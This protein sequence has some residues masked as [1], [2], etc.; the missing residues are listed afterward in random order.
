MNRRKKKLF[1]VSF[2]AAAAVATLAVAVWLYCGSSAVE[3]REI[4]V[5]L[6]YFDAADDGFSIAIL[7]DTHFG[8][9]DAPLA[10]KFVQLTSG[11]RPDMILL[12]GDFINGSPDPR[13]SMSME[14][15]ALFASSLHAK[16]GVFAVTGNH[17]LWYGR[18]KVMLA[19]RSAGV[20]VLS[21]KTQLIALPSGQKLQLAGFPDSTT[22]FTLPPP[23]IAP[24]LP[25]VALM[26]DAR[27]AALMP[28]FAFGVAGHTHGGQFRLCP[29]GGDRTSL[30]LLVQR[31]KDKLG[32]ISPAKRP[33]VLFDRWFTSYRGRKLFISAGLN[34]ERIRMRVFCPPEIVVMR[35][36][37]A[38]PQAAQNTYTVPEEL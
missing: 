29:D 38:D 35:L 11:L 10:E 19:L 16:Y 20:K 23:E 15:L 30:R 21:G 37:A 25:T 17:E 24:G 13:A 5:N 28:E 26:H 22:E 34:G 33:V 6:P 12:L 27:A 7:S 8:P 4:R 32:M 9:D 2:I 36:Y 1:L 31:I 18:K 14:D 3:I